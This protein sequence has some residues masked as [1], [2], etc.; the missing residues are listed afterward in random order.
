MPVYEPDRGVT[1]LETVRVSRASADQR[2]GRAGRTEPGIALRLWEE[3]QTASLPAFAEPE[4]RAADLSGLLL[5]CAAWG[6]TDPL[7]L[8]WLDPPPAP[9]LKE[10]RD[11][12]IRL[13]ALSG[14]GSITPLGR[15]MR[16]LPLPP[17]LARMVIAAGE[18]GAARMA[19][20]IAA[21]LVERGLGGDST[22]LTYRLEAFRR[23]RSA[24]AQEMRR[25]AEGWARQ[26]GGGHDGDASPAALLA[27]AF[28]DRIAKARGAPGQFLLANGRGAGVEPSD[29]LARHGHLVVAELSGKASAGRILLAAPFDEDELPALAGSRLIVANETVFDSTAKALRA[30]RVTRLGGIILKSEPRALSHGP[31]AAAALAAGAA[32]AGI[33]RLGWSRAQAQMRDRIAFLRAAEGADWPDLSDSTLAETVGQWLAPFLEG[34]SALSDIDAET[35]GAALQALIPYA[36]VRRLDEEAPTHFE[37]PTGNRHPIDYESEGAPILAIRVQELFGLREHPSIAAGNC[38]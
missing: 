35:L 21:L 38:R 20:E 8:S 29:P 23:D 11:E 10:A 22:D 3:G 17:R 4:I 31:E 36:L 24:R 18:R 6:V 15:R 9:A 12:L 33:D 19:A 28:P 1:R 37:A 34:K 25:L 26:A 16:A 2:R 7:T 30:R 5:D 13:E 27:L 32:T 14:T